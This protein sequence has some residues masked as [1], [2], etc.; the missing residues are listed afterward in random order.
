MT[1]SRNTSTDRPARV[2]GLAPGERP[3]YPTQFT[4]YMVSRAGSGTWTHS[5]GVEEA[6][7]ATP[8]LDAALYED[9]RR[10][11][12]PYYADFT[13][14][15]IALARHHCARNGGYWTGLIDTRLHVLQK[16]GLITF[17]DGAWHAA[18]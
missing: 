17:L 16:L 5:T 3:E 18:S 4:K 1:C 15:T 12:R 9:I 2:C 8:N 10:V 6:V 14:R 13:H 11:A 7:G